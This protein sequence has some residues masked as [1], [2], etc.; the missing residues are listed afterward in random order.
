MHDEK[1]KLFLQ[2]YIAQV[3]KAKQEGI[4]V[5]GFFVWSLTDNFVWAEGYQP[6]FGLIH[7]DFST[8]KRTIKSSGYWYGNFLQQLINNGSIINKTRISA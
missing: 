8:Q 5:K 7:V 3:L 1:R 4:N 2:Q 6:R